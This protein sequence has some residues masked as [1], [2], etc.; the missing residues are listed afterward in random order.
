[1]RCGESERVRV[2]ARS[3]KT[4]SAPQP[5][6]VNAAAHTSEGRRRRRDPRV[7]KKTR[8]LGSHPPAE[9]GRTVLRATA[10]YATGCNRPES[11]RAALP[12]SAIPPRIVH[13]LF[14]EASGNS[15]MAESGVLERQPHELGSALLGRQHSLSS[16]NRHTERCRLLRVTMNPRNPSL[17]PKPERDLALTFPVMTAKQLYTP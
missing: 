3:W 11:T 7:H 4:G 16:L 6:P 1:M 12:P 9:L 5:L 2:D 13:S 8:K 15:S 17:I 14:E 10:Q